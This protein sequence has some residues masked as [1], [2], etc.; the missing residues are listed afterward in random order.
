MLGFRKNK[1][2]G[3]NDAEQKTGLFA[4][5]KSGL[6]RT[7]H[8]L[9]EGV[10]SLVLGSKRID[11]DLLEEIETSLLVADVGVE[12]T[13]EIITFS[14][15]VALGMT[16]PNSHPTIADEMIFIDDM[17][18]EAPDAPPASGCASQTGPTLPRIACRS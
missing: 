1:T 2:S 11:D 5:L 9:T 14:I 18:W 13:R 12:A 15:P 4:R 16:P 7:R 3:E 6:S 10:A 17:A 8:S